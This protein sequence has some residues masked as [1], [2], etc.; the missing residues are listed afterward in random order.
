M[1]SNS[2]GLTNV[3]EEEIDCVNS[4][5]LSLEGNIIDFSVTILNNILILHWCSVT[6]K[7]VLIFFCFF[8]KWHHSQVI[9]W[10]YTKKGLHED[11]D[12]THLVLAIWDNK[13]KWSL[14]GYLTNQVRSALNS[15]I[16]IIY[17]SCMT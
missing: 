10:V 2:C 15:L 5:E 14:N 3:S 8:L 13:T 1:K 12:L 11:L 17:K 6:Q 4:L 9:T 16:F 7:K